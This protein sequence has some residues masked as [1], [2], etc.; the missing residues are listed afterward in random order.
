[1]KKT[2][3]FARAICA[4]MLMSSSVSAVFA[5]REDVGTSAAAFLKIGPGARPAAM[6]E[7]QTAVSDDV[8]SIFHNPSGLA[9]VGGF[10]FTAQYGMHF[11]S[12]AYNVLGVAYPVGKVGTFGIGV[13]NL[14]VNAIERRTQDEAVAEGDFAAGDY[15]YVLSY[16]RKICER[17]S[18]GANVK[19]LYS[20]ID[21]KSASAVAADAG[22][23]ARPVD[24]S[25]LSVG[26]AAQNLG[27]E[28]KF[29]TV[30]DPLPAVYKLG[31][32]YRFLNDDLL[33]AVDVAWPRDN[34]A[35]VSAGL[36]YFR[37][38][39]GNFA[40]SLRAGYKSVTD[41]KL[42]GRAG[43]SAGAGVVFRQFK[44]DF[45]WVP[46]GLLGDSFRYALSVKF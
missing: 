3:T 11:Q 12:I 29:D 22:I 43:L 28:M 27:G 5:A 42:E 7:A 24:G 17:V 41:E 16:G 14:A 34:A 38:I 44:F 39:D 6:A 2:K 15:A 30:G 40:G 23:I 45:A 32:G 1:M 25:P 9:A 20:T 19:Y 37:R 13:I 46:Y 21:D 36:E 10:E 35:R 18:A 33:T 26:A 31:I 8:N 4:A